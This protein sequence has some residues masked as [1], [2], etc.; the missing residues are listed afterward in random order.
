MSLEVLIQSWHG[1]ARSHE[2][3]ILA[4]FGTRWDCAVVIL[5]VVFL[6]VDLGVKVTLSRELVTSKIDVI[7]TV[8]MIR[9]APMCQDSQ[10]K[11]SLCRPND[12]YSCYGCSASSTSF[13]AIVS[14]LIWQRYIRPR[15][16]SNK[17]PFFIPASQAQFSSFSL[18]FMNHFHRSRVMIKGRLPLA[19]WLAWELQGDHFAF[20]VCIWYAYMSAP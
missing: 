4:F 9:N 18:V 16:L 7:S 10:S 15:R 19:W 1:P 6:L 12:Y 14:R 2:S 5:V 20:A 13:S 17:Q 8:N 3:S 11:D